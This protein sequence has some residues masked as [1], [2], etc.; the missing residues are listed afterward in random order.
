[1]WNRAEEMIAR[2]HNGGL[3]PAQQ[4]TL[5]AQIHSIVWAGLRFSEYCDSDEVGTVQYTPHIFSTG[6]GLSP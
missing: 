1:M 3:C 4:T 6:Y 2:I 5:A